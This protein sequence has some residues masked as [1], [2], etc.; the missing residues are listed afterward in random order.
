MDY[1]LEFKDEAQ[2]DRIMEKAYK[3]KKAMIELCEAL[4]EADSNSMS[5]RGRYR[6]GGGSRS[7]SGGGSSGGSSSSYRRGRYRD[8]DDDFDMDDRE[9]MRRG[10][11]GY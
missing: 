2:L 5:E 10:R 7:R 1:I 3:A 4:E 11:Y 6:E 9:M 8:N